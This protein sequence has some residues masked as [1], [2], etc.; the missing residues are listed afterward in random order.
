MRVTNQHFVQQEINSKL[1][2][3]NGSVKNILS[4]HL[5]SKNIKI[6]MQK[7]DNFTYYVVWLWKLAS[8]VKRT[9]IEDI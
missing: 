6:T 9:R 8:H 5:L 2:F 1:N 4:S 3:E 7:N